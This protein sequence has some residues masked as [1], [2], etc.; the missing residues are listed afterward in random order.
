[1]LLMVIYLK[2]I[3]YLKRKMYWWAGQEELQESE[4]IPGHHAVQIKRTVHHRLYVTIG[5]EHGVRKQKAIV[6]NEE[7]VSIKR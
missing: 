3:N 7:E 2:Q 4:Y 1:M 5:C 6:G